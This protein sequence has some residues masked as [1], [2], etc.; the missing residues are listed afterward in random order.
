M[1]TK[2]LF[3]TLALSGMFAAC[4]QEE[5]VSNVE[6]N[7]EALNNRPTAGMVEFS[8]GD[9]ESRY[10]HQYAEF[11]VGESLDLYLMDELNGYYDESDANHMHGYAASKQCWKY[12]SVWS[13]MYKFVNYAQTRYP[14]AYNGKT[15][16]NEATLLEG[17]YFAMHPGNEKIT[18][19][20]DVWRYINPTI[21]LTDEEGNYNKFAGLVNQFWLGYTPI[22]RD[23]DRTGDMTLPL[24]M[25]PIMTVAKLTIKN[26]GNTD[27]KIDK[28]VF[29]DQNGKALPTIAYV[30]PVSREDWRQT[31][32][33]TAIRT[34]DDCKDLVCQGN[35]LNTVYDVEKTWNDKA[36]GR[37][38]ARGIVHYDNPAKRI[39]YGLEDTEVAY[40]YVYQFPEDG[41]FL[42][43][44]EPNGTYVQVYIV[45]PHTEAF[46]Y[47]PIIYGRQ[48][49]K[50]EEGTDKEWAYGILRAKGSD[51]AIF[52]LNSIDLD[53]AVPYVQDVTASFDQY[54]FEA[55][56]EV[57]VATTEDLMTMLKASQPSFSHEIGYFFNVKVYGDDLKIT[58]EVV[59]YLDEKAKAVGSTDTNCKLFL[60]FT[61]LDTRMTPALV[62]IDTEKDCM[63]YFRFSNG[64]V[65]VN[66]AKGEHTIPANNKI[67][68]HFEDLTVLEGA[69]LTIEDPIKAR[70]VL[71][72]GTLNV[73]AYVDSTIDNQ[74]V[75]NIAANIDE[76]RNE[77]E[78]NVTGT[79][80]VRKFIN[81]NRCV[82]C[83]DDAAVL[84]I[85]EDL[86]EVTRKLT[87]TTLEN[88]DSVVNNGTL[89]ATTFL[90]EDEGTADMNGNATLKNLTNK[91]TLNVNSAVTTIIKGQNEGTITVAEGAE[92]NVT[93]DSQLV[94]TG[95]IEVSGHLFSQ[96]ANYA[97][98]F[99]IGNGEVVVNGDLNTVQSLGNVAGIID[100]TQANDGINA[101]A[102]KDMASENKNKKN[103]FRYDVNDEETAEELDAALKARISEYNYYASENAEAARII[104]RWTNATTATEFVGVTESNIQKLYI[105]K[106]LDFVYD[107]NN[108]V[109]SFTKLEDVCWAYGIYNGTKLYYPAVV[110]GEN[111]KVQVDSFQTLTFTEG[112]LYNW[113]DNEDGLVQA[114]ALTVQVKAGAELKVN[115]H[116]TV[117]D[118]RVVLQGAGK[119]INAGA[120]FNW[121]NSSI[122]GIT[123][124]NRISW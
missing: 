35:T 46:T 59:K 96:I 47:E 5:L 118:N 44:G 94:N 40:E 64:S 61:A 104:V 48:F 121:E 101:H 71:N 86:T 120:N 97:E 14:F 9:V 99:V 12:F 79:A 117:G 68:N 41:Y 91:G 24:N 57:K 3:F 112:N 65:D 123:T 32:D 115:N 39:P 2:H 90:N 4:T 29:K 113:Q 84:T 49:M 102:A 83:G 27:T 19:R 25:Q 100:I 20:R 10:N 66:V 56:T 54:S 28:I 119:V 70:F 67:K 53:K 8:L 38:T 60:D 93:G 13:D 6:N 21:S 45:L 77:A 80:V 31:S 18:N 51:N 42:K 82:N 103:Y 58:D 63:K 88:K 52:T 73:N 15:W 85:F 62:T 17:N 1:K 34:A 33:V 114:E 111:V 122:S 72:E 37:I 11:N 87:V 22:Y 50:E 124:S 69:T 43:G 105:N 107:E 109:T 116:A 98:I 92:V 76:V 108:S 23:E 110:I 78:A 74:G 16:S 106:N 95:I 81:D 89:I 7:A 36:E 75:L 55:L 26:T 30:K